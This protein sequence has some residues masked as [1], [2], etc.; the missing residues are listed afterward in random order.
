MGGI[1]ASILGAIS[2][3][4]FEVLGSLFGGPRVKKVEDADPVMEQVKEFSNESLIDRFANTSDLVSTE[5][6]T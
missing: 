4:L 3:S 5:G 6:I 1:I 2:K